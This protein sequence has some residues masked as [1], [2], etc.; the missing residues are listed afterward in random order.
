MHPLPC[1]SAH[2]QAPQTRRE[3]LKS[4]LSLNLEKEDKNHWEPDSGT[5]GPAP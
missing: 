4:A 2:T 3:E 1:A 5:R